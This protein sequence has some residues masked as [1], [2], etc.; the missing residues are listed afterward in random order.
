MNDT[1]L[2][3]CGYI[4]RKKENSNKHFSFENTKETATF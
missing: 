4:M 3:V 1:L 2:Q